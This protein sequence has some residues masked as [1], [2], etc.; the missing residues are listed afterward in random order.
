MSTHYMGMS[1]SH[2]PNHHLSPLFALPEFHD[3]CLPEATGHRLHTVRLVGQ[4]DQGIAF[5]KVVRMEGVITF[6]KERA[7]R[8]W[9]L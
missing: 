5:P 8:L 4:K 2:H 6:L 7:L 1:C 3:Q 9:F